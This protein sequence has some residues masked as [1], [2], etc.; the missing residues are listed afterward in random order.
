MVRDCLQRCEPIVGNYGKGPQNRASNRWAVPSLR[1][2]EAKRGTVA[3][4]GRGE[5]CGEVVPWKNCDP[6]CGNSQQR[7]Q[8]TASI[9]LWS[10]QSLSYVFTE[11]PARIQKQESLLMSCFSAAFLGT[12]KAAEG[13]TV[14]C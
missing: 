4:V 11:N 6:L 10:Y 8:G 9:S 13:G 12:E 14:H 5:A 7:A 3:R 2:I 1:P